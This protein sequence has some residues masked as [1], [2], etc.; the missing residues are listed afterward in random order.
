MENFIFSAVFKSYVEE[1]HRFFFK[2]FPWFY[3]VIKQNLII[4]KSHAKYNQ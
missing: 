1:R 2:K 3:M 4:V